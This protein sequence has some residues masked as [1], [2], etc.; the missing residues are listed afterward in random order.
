MN[1]DDILVTLANLL[2]EAGSGIVRIAVLRI[3]MEIVVD[4]IIL[5]KNVELPLSE[6]SHILPQITTT[7]PLPK[8]SLG[9]PVIDRDVV[10][11]VGRKVRTDNLGTSCNFH[12][13]VQVTVQLETGE[14]IG[15][16]TI[17]VECT[18]VS[19]TEAP[20]V[21]GCRKTTVHYTHLTLPTILRV[22]LSVVHGSTTQTTHR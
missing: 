20:I 11:N 3:L 19:T 22:H 7:S 10:S 4:L 16:N 1:M 21:R 9:L 6:M 14:V 15:T 5:L 13:D 12:V 2:I 8:A 18:R 17:A